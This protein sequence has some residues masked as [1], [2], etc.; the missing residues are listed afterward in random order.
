MVQ[1]GLGEPSGGKSMKK[2]K[3][4]FKKLFC[5]HNRMV[6]SYQQDA[7]WWRRDMPTINGRHSNIVLEGCLDCGKTWV[8][9][10]GE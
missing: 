10:F 7:T 6:K 4:I 8:R 5:K 2:M 1:N 9:D 3:R